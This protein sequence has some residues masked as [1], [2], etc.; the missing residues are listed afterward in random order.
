MSC[1]PPLAEIALQFSTFEYFW[2]ALL[3]LMCATLVARS[4]PVKA[5]AS[6][7]IALLSFVGVQFNLRRAAS[8]EYVSQLEKRVD[9]QGNDLNDLKNELRECERARKELQAENLD[10]MRK[11]VGKA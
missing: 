10:L 2:L 11:L 3:G 8:T 9:Q 4:S 1:S 7:F 5:I 6:M